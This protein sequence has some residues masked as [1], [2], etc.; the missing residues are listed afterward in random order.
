MILSHPD[1]DHDRSHITQSHP[2]WALFLSFEHERIH[3]ETS[4]ILIRE[5][6]VDLVEY[7]EYWPSAHASIPLTDIWNPQ[8]KKDYPE[9]EELVCAEK[10]VT[11]GKP[12]N[13]PS[14][15]WDNEYGARVEG[16]RIRNFGVRMDGNGKIFEMPS[17]QHFGLQS[18]HKIFINTAFA[19]FLKY[20]LCLG[21][22]LLK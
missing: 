2:L 9:N 15:G 17:G 8:Q 4:S 18:D 16:I 11:L 22:G 14:F 1:L 6:P 3:L 7:P 13:G 21:L 20:T 12:P 19:V 5:L 10:T